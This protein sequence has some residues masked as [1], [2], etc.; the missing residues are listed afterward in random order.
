MYELVSPR[1]PLDARAAND[2]TFVLTPND[3][4]RIGFKDL[5][6]DVQ[7]DRL[8]MHRGT[9]LLTYVRQRR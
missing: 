9:A 4:G 2:F 3:L 5:V 1:F 6:V 8:V 7:R